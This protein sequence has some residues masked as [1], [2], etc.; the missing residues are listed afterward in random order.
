MLLTAGAVSIA[1]CQSVRQGQPL[2]LEKVRDN[3]F[4]IAGSGGNTA[5][6]IT[7]TGV[8]VVDTKTPGNGA[9]ILDQIR[10]V[11]TKPV[12]IVIN[13]HTHNDHVGS[14]GEL[15]RPIEIIAHA[16][17]RANMERMT[18]FQGDGAA[19]LPQRTFTDRQ[20]LLSG[21]DRVDLYYFGRGHT[22]GDAI[23][24]F[25][26]LRAAHT[27]DLFF[28]PV[29]PTIDV[30]NG[31]SGLEYPETLRKAATAITDVDLVIPGHSG[32]TT[33]SAFVEYGQFV[34][35]LVA[36]IQ[37]AHKEGKNA[38]NAA[39]GQT[40]PEKF[41]SYDLGFVRSIVAAVYGELGR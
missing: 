35:A 16:N 32:V 7:S 2:G 33:W 14:N 11:T 26:A 12:T 30:D 1:V 41:R 20:T 6:F 38:R 10:K 34:Q 4:V 21:D 3:L 29:A 22:S 25:P 18:A 37:Q 28:A 15:P 40:L 17:T 39:S 13:T 23:V 31:G 36:A 19:N 8:V 5:A 27:G 9:K 24:V